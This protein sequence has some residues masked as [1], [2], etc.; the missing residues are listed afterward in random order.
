MKA[1]PAAILG[2]ISV[3]ALTV[4]ASPLFAQCP[5]AP[6]DAWR[7]W[8]DYVRV[9]S[10][11]G[12]AIVGSGVERHCVLPPNWCGASS[13]STN[14]SGPTPEEIE[15]ERVDAMNDAN[16]KGIYYFEH[17]KWDLA[18]QNF[19]EALE[20]SPYNPSLKHNIERAKEEKAKEEQEAREREDRLHRALQE[21]AIAEQNAE[22]NAA[23][24]PAQ[25]AATIAPQPSQETHRTLTYAELQAKVNNTTAEIKGLQLAILRLQK[26][27][28]NTVVERQAWNDEMEDAGNRAALHMID[29]A[30]AGLIERLETQN[31]QL[32]SEIGKAVD[33]LAGETDP[34]R[35]AQ[36]H[37]ALAMME[38]EK[39][40]LTP[41]MERV[42]LESLTY[43]AV[44]LGKSMDDGDSAFQIAL[45]Q[46]HAN[47][48]RLLKNPALVRKLESLAGS[49]TNVAFAKG[50]AAWLSV[51]KDVLDSGYDLSCSLVALHK[52]NNS[53][54]L[55]D[56]EY[57]HAVDLLKVRMEK[58]VTALNSYKRQ[59][60]RPSGG[61]RS[62]MA[63]AGAT[64][65]TSPKQ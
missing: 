21:Q 17:R 4:L 5:V 56:A 50:A 51:G 13:A 8:N 31:S 30:T 46:A 62:V 63:N 44:K 34:N 52:M 12:G 6:P 22:Q 10:R 1:V 48:G 3:A 20:Y 64:S 54:A 7:T 9:C 55:E 41:V 25:A 45:D 19:E 16:E 53:L 47:L 35:R 42:E 57:K 23:P 11:Y 36:L 15:Q 26:S 61:A 28:N 37:A 58:A 65:H 43:D 18:I 38:R 32:Q 40:K 39:A 29:M 27:H 60:Q 14:P 2:S 24:K 59:M 33:R 49:S